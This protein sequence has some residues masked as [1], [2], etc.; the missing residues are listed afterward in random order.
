MIMIYHTFPNTIFPFRGRGQ[1]S[2]SI[3]I[4]VM[5][6]CR[7]KVTDKNHEDKYQRYLNLLYDNEIKNY[8]FEVIIDN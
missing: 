5:S 4:R 2:M 3:R 1:E 8:K 6:L 7:R